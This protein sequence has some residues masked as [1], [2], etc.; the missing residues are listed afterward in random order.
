[1]MR[2]LL[3]IIAGT[4]AFAAGG[5]LVNKLLHDPTIW[6]PD[7]YVEYWAAGRLNLVGNNPYSKATLWPLQQIAGRKLDTVD[8]AVMMWNPPW[9]LSFVMPLGALPARV[10]QF[11]WLLVHLGAMAASALLLWTTYAGPRNRAMLAIGLCLVF[12]PT[13]FALNTGQISLFLLLGLAGY[14]WCLKHGYPFMA[15]LCCVLIAI[16]PHLLYLLWLAIGMDAILAES[17][18]KYLL[19]ACVVRPSP[20]PYR[21]RSTHRFGI[22]TPRRIG[23]IPRRSTS[24]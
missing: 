1:M 13:L 3:T 9:T 10:G 19:V 20:S 4:V 23:F 21:W 17:D 22:T 18:G 5:L 12:V 14:A 15:G 8:D 7:D 16:K 11:V 24:R 6:P 2:Q